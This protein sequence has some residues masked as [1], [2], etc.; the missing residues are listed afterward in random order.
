MLKMCAG[1]GWSRINFLLS[2]NTRAMF[3]ISAGNTADN[4][5]VIVIAELFSQRVKAFSAAHIMPEKA[6]GAQKA[7]RGHRWDS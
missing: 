2:S 1:F 7:R 6:G 3:W 5:D 4:R